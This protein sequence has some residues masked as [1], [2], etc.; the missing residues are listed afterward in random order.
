MDKKNDILVAALKLFVEHGFHGTPTSKIAQEAG[1]ANGTI[2]HY[3]KTKEELIIALYVDIKT[4]LGACM[5]SEIDE[6][7]GY[8][9]TLK[10]IF[11]ETLK[12]ALANKTEFNFIQQFHSSPFI[13]LVKNEVIAQ[14]TQHHIDL[15]AKGIKKKHLKELPVELLFTLVSSHTFGVYQ[16]LTTANLSVIKTKKIINESFD[17]IW[18]MIKY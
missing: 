5:Y 13:S 12:W 17:L 10:T 15:L 2:F 18:K 14:Q 7:M 16:Y 9:N 1:V 6:S 3:Y 11:N 4:R 8:E